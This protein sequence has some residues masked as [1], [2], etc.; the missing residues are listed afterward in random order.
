MSRW[1]CLGF[2]AR[3][4]VCPAV[5]LLQQG[6]DGKWR[7]S[8]TCQDVLNIWSSV[9]SSVKRKTWSWIKW[10]LTFPLALLSF[11]SVIQSTGEIHWDERRCLHPQIVCG[12]WE[13]AGL[14]FSTYE[15]Q[16][17]CSWRCVTKSV[18]FL[19]LSRG[20]KWE[21]DSG[22]V[23]PQS[24]AIQKQTATSIDSRISVSWREVLGQGSYF[25]FSWSQQTSSVDHY[26]PSEP[27]HS[28]VTLRIVLQEAATICLKLTQG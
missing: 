17:E 6:P 5:L 27:G 22:P 3:S 15:V 12:M 25:L 8:S 24:K 21:R 1:P 10:S 19:D 2:L 7:F 20:W 23:S 18:S 13:A 16:G 4:V 9:S 26:T 14:S 28:F 11:G